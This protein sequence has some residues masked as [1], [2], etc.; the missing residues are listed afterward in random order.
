MI[1]LNKV[2]AE[3]KLLAKDKD[4]KLKDA[5]ELIAQQA[6]YKDWKSY[7]D[8]LDIDWYAKHSPFL[9]KWF[10]QYENALQHLNQYGG[11]LLTYKGQFFIAEKE[12][13]RHLG[14][15]PE[16]EVWQRVGFDASSAKSANLLKKYL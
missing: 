2:K 6:Q 16:N 12:Y 1:S 3:A 15:D 4:L 8:S 14:F 13:I 9:N 11:F 5:F 10:A 7:K